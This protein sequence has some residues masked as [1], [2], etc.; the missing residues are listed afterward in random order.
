MGTLKERKLRSSDEMTN[1]AEHFSAEPS[2]A[3]AAEWGIRQG[4]SASSFMWG[5]LYNMLLEWI[6]PE[7]MHLYQAEAPTPTSMLTPRAMAN[8]YADDLATLTCGHTAFYWQ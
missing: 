7:Q 1:H 8:V 2:L 5:A 3:F 4:E 6:D